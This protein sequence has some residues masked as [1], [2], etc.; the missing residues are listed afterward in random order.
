MALGYSSAA[1]HNGTNT[2]YYRNTTHTNF[3]YETFTAMGSG[4]ETYIKNRW[5]NSDLEMME[6]SIPQYIDNQPFSV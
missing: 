4:M 5:P 1:Y 2:F 6:Y 3:G